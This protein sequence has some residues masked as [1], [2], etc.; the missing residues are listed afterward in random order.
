MTRGSIIDRNVFSQAAHDGECQK[1]NDFLSRL[2]GQTFEELL[3]E[4]EMIN[5]ME[6]EDIQQVSMTSFQDWQMVA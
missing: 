5:K 1:L 4:M 3:I 2:Y 6:P